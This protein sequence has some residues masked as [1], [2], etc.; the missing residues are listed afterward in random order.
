MAKLSQEQRDQVL[1]R[2]A[3]G[4]SYEDAAR[5]CASEWQIKI[6]KQAIAKLV[7]RHRTE[8]KDVAKAVA[9]D[10]IARQLPR[11]LTAADDRHAQAARLVDLAATAC[12]AEPTVANFEKYSK[13][14][15]A[16][17]RWEELRRKTLGLDQPD[18]QIVDSVIGL[19]GLA[20]EDEERAAR[21][22]MADDE[23]QRAADD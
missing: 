2:V 6:S 15:Q 10:H 18:D 1:V 8:R 13:A 11:D 14:S 9:R 3:S 22:A 21:A 17:I 12:E 19:L 5:W 16:L 23:P 7:A 20:L 4:A